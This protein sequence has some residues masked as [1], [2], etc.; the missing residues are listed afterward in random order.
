MRMETVHLIA[1]VAL[2][3]SIAFAIGASDVGQDLVYTWSSLWC[4]NEK[5]TKRVESASKNASSV[6]VSLVVIY[7]IARVF[8]YV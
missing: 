5:C 6:A 8:G 3:L 2:A 7:V 4:N 1:L